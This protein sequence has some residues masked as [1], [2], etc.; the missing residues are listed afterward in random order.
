L[1]LV[2]QLRGGEALPGIPKR[3]HLVLSLMLVN[4]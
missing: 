1:P 4:G 3:A 2:A